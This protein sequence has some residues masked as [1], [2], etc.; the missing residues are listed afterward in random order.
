MLRH[1]GPVCIFI[2]GRGGR[3]I[4][5]RQPLNRF[6]FA[7][8]R[9][10]KFQRHEGDIQS[11]V[12]DSCLLYSVE[13]NCEFEPQLTA[14]QPTA[15]RLFLTL[16]RLNYCQSL[17]VGLMLARLNF[18]SFDLMTRNIIVLFADFLGTVAVAEDKV[19]EAR[20]GKLTA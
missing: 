4:N 8:A 19:T 2:F 6:S 15:T 18:S 14:T 5:E 13:F 20:R 11:V 9:Q 7:K 10:G 17:P 3:P 16:S 1:S 12:F